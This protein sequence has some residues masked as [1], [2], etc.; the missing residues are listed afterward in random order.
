MAGGGAAMMAYGVYAANQTTGTF[1]FSVWIFILPFIG[2]GYGI[3][4]TYAWAT[5]KWP[6]GLS[7][8][9]DSINRLGKGSSSGNTGT[10][11]MA[12]PGT[13]M[14]RH[15]PPGLPGQAPPF[16]APGHPP[17]PTPPMASPPTSAAPTWIASA[18]AQPSQTPIVRPQAA[19]SRSTPPPAP[20]QS[21]PP[22]VPPSHR[23]SPVAPTP[24]PVEV[25]PP[26]E[27]TGDNATPWWVQDQPG[28]DPPSP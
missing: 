2:L 19:P 24:D 15:A 20:P 8:V 18:Q 25:V 9:V 10:A 13:P 28:V 6:N 3:L 14:P 4:S 21:A 12:P 5:E 7:G 16:P 27:G 22:T 23:V 17:T 26:T 11:G 1:Y